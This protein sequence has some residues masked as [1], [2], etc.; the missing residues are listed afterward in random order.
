MVY[1]EYLLPHIN[2]KYIKSNIDDFCLIRHSHLPQ[3]DLLDTETKRL[4]NKVIAMGAEKVLP[5]YSISLYGVF[6]TKDTEIK[7]INEV[8]LEY[9]P[10][11]I[12]VDVPIYDDDFCLKKDRGYWSVLI[13]D[14]NN[15]IIMYDDK[16]LKAKCVVNHTPMKWNFWHF[17]LNWY[18]YNLDGYWKDK[19]EL[20]SKS[21]RRKLATEA[22]SLLKE[23]SRPGILT[24]KII[25]NHYYLEQ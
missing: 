18:L 19:K 11:N 21:I 9:C 7:I 4:K 1:P 14:V 22:R 8:Y 5:D 16:S 2:Y 12:E 10:P 23:Y 20:V 24:E 25:E 6:K 3:H 13:G 15:K 17:S